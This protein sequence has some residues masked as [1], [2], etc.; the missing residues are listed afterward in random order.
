MANGNGNTSTRRRRN[1]RTTTGIR[2][3]RRVV[4]RLETGIKFTPGPDPPEFARAPWWSATLVWNFT[5]PGTIKFSHVQSTLLTLMGATGFVTGVKDGKDVVSTTPF[6]VRPVTVR[7]WGLEKQPMNMEVFEI[8]GG[9]THRVAQL[10]D[11]GSGINFSRMGWRFG[12]AARV[13]PNINE[14]VAI[15]SL[16]PNGK[17]MVY[18]QVL[19]AVKAGFRL[20]SAASDP[21]SAV[22]S[23]FTVMDINDL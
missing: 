16:T 5:Q 7:A 2:R 23:G 3:I 6:V 20:T 1:T 14:A 13:D 15:V 10:A 9:G 22:S 21:T 11:M 19:F 17:A 4:D 12:V 8:L 18:L